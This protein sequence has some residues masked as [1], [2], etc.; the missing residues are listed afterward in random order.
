[1]GVSPAAATYIT[2]FGLIAAPSNQYS[3]SSY[4][5]GDI[6]AANYNAPTPA[7]L[8]TA[9]SDM[10][11]A[12]TNAAGAS[13]TN[14]TTLNLASGLLNGQTLTPGVYTWGSSVTITNILT[15]SGSGV[16]IFQISGNLNTASGAQ[17][18]LTNGAQ[19][20]D[21]FW[22]VAGQTTFG[23]GSAVSGVVLDQ[24]G[25]ALQTGATL[26]GSAL[27][28]T[29]V[30]LDAA[31]VTQ[32]TGSGSVPVNTSTVATTT[33]PAATT[34]TSSGGGT[35]VTTTAPSVGSGGGGS[36]AP[37]TTVSGSGST[38]PTTT[39]ATGTG[40]TYQGVGTYQVKSSTGITADQYIGNPAYFKVL[41][42]NGDSLTYVSSAAA[43]VSTVPTTTTASGGGGSTTTPQTSGSSTGYCTGNYSI[44]QGVVAWF[45]Q[46]FGWKC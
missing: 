43:P 42:S 9:I 16:Y 36:T 3:T 30:T 4:V 28:Q 20:Q 22:Q 19:P 13:T 17:I 39:V 33:A 25:I 12:Y 10:Q 26:T 6:F 46:S 7:M 18:V 45:Y 14:A 38:A 15:L 31:T 32:S 29:A 27:A 1:M 23:T 35:T 24:T 11:T 2:G 8:T 44:F 21:I 41:L 5:T 37:T 34:T 40:S